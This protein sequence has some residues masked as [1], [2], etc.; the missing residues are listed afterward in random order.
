MSTTVWTYQSADETQ[1]TIEQQPDG[2]QDLE[3][4]LS[5]KTPERVELLLGMG[6]VLDLALRVVDTLGDGAGKL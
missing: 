6:H 5:H 1:D 3:Q 4:W 2:S